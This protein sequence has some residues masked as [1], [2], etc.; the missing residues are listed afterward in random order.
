MQKYYVEKVKN[1]VNGEWH[2][3]TGSDHVT[4]SN[5][6]TGDEL[7]KVPVGTRAD[8]DA[9]VAAAKAAFPGWSETPV[10]VRSRYL[11]ELRNVMEK[12]FEELCSICTQEH[13]KT[14]DESKG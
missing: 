7:G 2:S 6:A 11:F 3:S 1:Y 13:G 10:A 14:F 8:V 9:A 12:H 5:P 4:V